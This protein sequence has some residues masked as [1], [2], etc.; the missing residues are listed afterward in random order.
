[1]IRLM[2]MTTLM[3]IVLSV[4][5]G[6]NSRCS[7]TTPLSLAAQR[8][9]FGYLRLI[10]KRK[11]EGFD[12][13]ILVHVRPSLGVYFVPPCVTSVLSSRSRQ[14]TPFM[15]RVAPLLYVCVLCLVSVYVYSYAL[16]LCMCICLCR[17][18]PVS[19]IRYALT[20]LSSKSR[21]H[22]TKIVSESV[23]CQKGGPDFTTNSCNAAFDPEPKDRE[24]P[25]CQGGT[26]QCRFN[27][28]IK[29]SEILGASQD[30]RAAMHFQ[31]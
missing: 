16:C 13:D 25:N 8:L 29:N 20:L 14:L 2:A 1:M 3:S 6:A 17:C 30:S 12:P 21:E 10:R 22:Q 27:F 5:A 11:K 15:Q 28:N 31:V 19:N 26:V 7:T 9:S 24:F 4:V 18:L 23:Q